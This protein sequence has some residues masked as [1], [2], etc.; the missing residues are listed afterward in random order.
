MC[1]PCYQLWLKKNPSPRLA[2]LTVIGKICRGCGDDKPFSEYTKARQ[3][4]S[5]YHAQ[6]KDCTRAVQK[7]YREAN[8]EK[9]KEYDRRWRENTAVYREQMK[10]DYLS[11]EYR[12]STQL[13]RGWTNFLEKT[14]RVTPAEF[15]AMLESQSGGCAICG[16]KDSGAKNRQMHLDHC[17]KTG[18]NRGI[19]C[20]SC[21]VGLGNFKDDPDKLL[22]AVAYLLK[23][24]E[25]IGEAQASD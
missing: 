7:K 20:H 18:K 15:Y 12:K 13:A 14:Y 22:A 1:Y 16:R 6:C 2:N 3:N 23:N 24:A 8:P 9:G 5:G 10:P 25:V 17:H 19:L 21:N 11:A 4:T